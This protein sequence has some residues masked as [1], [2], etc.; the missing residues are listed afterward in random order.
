[1][2]FRQ[3]RTRALD[4]KFFGS[5]LVGSG[6]AQGFAKDFGDWDAARGVLI[7]SILADALGLTVNLIGTFQGLINGMA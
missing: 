1:M 2:A 6:A 4:L 3:M 5:A 7:A